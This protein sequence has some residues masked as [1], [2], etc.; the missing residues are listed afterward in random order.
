MIQQL[1][2]LSF[3]SSSFASFLQHFV[4]VMHCLASGDESRSDQR[5]LDMHYGSFSHPLL[6]IQPTEV[7]VVSQLINSTV[8]SS[9][10]SPPPVI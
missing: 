4:T 9:S 5:V 3:I 1:E 6:I 7:P 8:V 10:L 2:L